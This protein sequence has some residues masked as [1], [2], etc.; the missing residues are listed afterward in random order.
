[1]KKSVQKIHFYYPKQDTII[2]GIFDHFATSLDVKSQKM[3][4]RRVLI[5]QSRE[6]QNF[7]RL[8]RFFNS[9]YH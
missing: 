6:A 4:E 2:K 7:F 8:R 5:S 1:M 9:I 3:F